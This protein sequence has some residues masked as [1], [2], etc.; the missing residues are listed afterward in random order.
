MK[1]LLKNISEKTK[2]WSTQL[3]ELAISASYA[4]H[5]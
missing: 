2:E 4:I 1:D 3:Q 5:R